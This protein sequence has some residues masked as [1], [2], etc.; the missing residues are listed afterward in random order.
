M[1]LLSRCRLPQAVAAAAFGFGLSLLAAPA[2][3]AFTI[4]NQTVTNSDGAARYNNRDGT[5]SRYGNDGKTSIKQGNTTLQFGTHRRGSDLN[6][7]P[8]RMFQPNGRPYGE[9]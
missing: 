2:A 8:E 3:L 9:R 1:R 6:F 5:V 7:N 4:D